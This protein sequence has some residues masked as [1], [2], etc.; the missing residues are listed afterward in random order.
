MRTT[1]RRGTRI[2]CRRG[3]G[4]LWAPLAC[5]LGAAAR[6][7]PLGGGH[8]EAWLCIGRRGGKSLALALIA[9]FIACLRDW[10]PHLGPGE[11]GVIMCVAADRRQARIIIGYIKGLLRSARML[12]SLIESETRES[13]TLTNSITIEFHSASSKT[14]RGR[15]ARISSA[16]RPGDRAASLAPTTPAALLSFRGISTPSLT[17][18]G[19]QR[20]FSFFNIRRDISSANRGGKCR[21]T[22]ELAGLRGCGVREGSCSRNSEYPMP[23]ARSFHSESQ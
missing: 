2:V 1:E 20:R 21:A 12:A 19:E 18:Q 15:A 14:T 13:I 10:R 4:C 3:N 16:D 9:C 22:A 8:K 6:N 17:A 11:K 7:A 23:R 5:W